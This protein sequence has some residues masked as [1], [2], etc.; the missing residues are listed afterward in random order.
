MHELVFS[1]VGCKSILTIHDL[2]FLHN[3]KNPIKRFYKWLF[4]LYFPIKLSNKVIC[5]S[6]ETK[7]NILKS[8]KTDKLMVIPNPVDPMITYKPKLFNS[9]R[10]IILHIG[11]GW[12]KNLVKVVESLNGISCHLRIVGVLSEIQKKILKCTNIEYSNAINLSDSE[13]YQEYINCD[14]V[15]FP[16]IYEGFGMPIIEGQA[17]G[18]SVLT[19]KIEPLLEVS[20]NAAAY[21]NPNDLESIRNG[22]VKLIEDQEYRNK[23]IQMG[24]ENVKRYNVKI[25]AKRYLDVYNLLN[26]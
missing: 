24:L 14:I 26:S 17:T 12:N 13:I 20:G 10:P 4:W 6:S 11:T 25:L 18:R 1:L 16:S 8:I 21:V 3:A 2:V 7:K 9:A 19:S 23:C 22:F 15:S 5:I